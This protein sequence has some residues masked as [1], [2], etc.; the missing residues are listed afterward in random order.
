MT[1]ELERTFEGPSRLHSAA[2]T[3]D[4]HY[5]IAGSVN[6]LYIWDLRRGCLRYETERRAI[7]VSV[8][9][10]GLC[11]VADG[12]IATWDIE[13]GHVT[14]EFECNGPVE[15]LAVTPDGSKVIVGGPQF[16]HSLLQSY[17][18]IS[19][20]LLQVFHEGNDGIGAL[21]VTADGRNLLGAAG[22]AP[23]QMW[24]IQTAELQAEFEHPG[25]GSGIG[26]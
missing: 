6:G 12:R 22:D 3:P 17:E 4:G 7:A 20:R 15:A 19:G 26:D 14:G 24:D 18:T 1:G 23:V 10:S 25:N 9:L 11:L 21:A 16:G 8:S 5:L 2:I 13:A